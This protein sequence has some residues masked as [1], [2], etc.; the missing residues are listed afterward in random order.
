MDT[1][2]KNA[3]SWYESAF[4]KLLADKSALDNG[5]KGLCHKMMKA[6]AQA[7]K[8]AV[9]EIEMCRLEQDNVAEKAQATEEKIVHDQNIELKMTTPEKPVKKYEE[10]TSGAG[11]FKRSS[12]ASAQ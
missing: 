2:C 10:N 3:V 12:G 4:K 7:N 9:P 1:S 5:I 11:T 6:V 8:D